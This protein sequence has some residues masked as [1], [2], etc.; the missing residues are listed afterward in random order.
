MEVVASSYSWVSTWLKNLAGFLISLLGRS[1][2]EGVVSEEHLLLPSDDSSSR[3]RVDDLGNSWK[4][5]LSQ[6]FEAHP[7]EHSQATNPPH[8]VRILL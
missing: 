7:S 6:S 1:T 8:P 4:G 2:M 3:S 5:G